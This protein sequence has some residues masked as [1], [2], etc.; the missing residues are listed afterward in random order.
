M[1]IVLDNARSG[2][3]V[4]PLLSGTSSTVVLVTSRDSLAGL[5]ALHGAHRLDLDLLPP[6]D[7]VGLLHRLIGRRADAEPAATA[8]LAEQCARLPLALRVAAELANVRAAQPVTDLVAELADKQQRLE[9][10]DAGG[11]VHSTVHAVFSW[12]YQHLPVDAASAFRLLGQHP[13]ADLDAYATAAL[14][15]TS[16]R[17]ARRLLATL[18]R[19][20]LVQPV[21]AHR[22][23]LHDLLGAYSAGLTAAVDGEPGQQAA[24]TG[25][26]DYYLGTAAAAMDA[27]HPTGRHRRPRTAPATPTL[28]MADPD[29]ALAWLDT[30]RTNL[31]SMTALAARHGWSRRANDLGR[32]LYRYLDAGGHHRDALT[33][34]GHAYAAADRAGDPTGQAHASAGLG[35]VHFRLGR[36]DAAAETLGR[37][38]QLYGGIG[39]RAGEAHALINLGIL[40]WREGQYAAAADHLLPARVAYR[41]LGD[42]VGEART[43]NN[44]GLVYAQEGRHALAIDHHQQALVLFQETGDRSGEAHVLANLGSVSL[45]EGRH[46]LAAEHYRQALAR[47]LDIGDRRG[48]ADALNGLGESLGAAD[49]SAEARG[50][51]ETALTVAVE[52]GD[53]YEEARAHT[54]LG[55]IEHA[56]GQLG[57]ARRHWQ[58]ALRLYTDL[59]VPDAADLRTRL[60]TL[61]PTVRVAGP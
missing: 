39:D 7:A 38:L 12:S 19:A 49:R 43:L 27:V 31:V 53:R 45:R 29:A 16:L 36:Y 21:G 24:L 33:I 41:E 46:D 32:T 15:G 50:R 14:A 58:H 28:P 4:R 20:H 56:T 59:G 55:R 11:D 34:H 51:H 25:L 44:L 60:S 48:E 9:C 1:L 61:D 35:L 52:T 40:R 57:S 37:A 23:A 13:G 47:F 30:E 54:G 5:V 2:E 17:E 26:F 18:V 42:R 10:L 8:V 6:A 3:Q 22:Y